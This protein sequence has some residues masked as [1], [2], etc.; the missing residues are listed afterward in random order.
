M[1]TVP[2][3]DPGS[4]SRRDRHGGRGGGGK[5]GGGFAPR[6]R[7]NTSV[8]TPA[9]YI[10]LKMSTPSPQEAQYGGQDENLDLNQPKPPYSS[11]LSRS[12]SFPTFP[13][14]YISLAAAYVFRKLNICSSQHIYIAIPPPPFVHY[15]LPWFYRFGWWLRGG[16]YWAIMS[17]ITTGRSAVQNYHF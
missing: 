2:V 9:S 10:L 12:L 14:S 13:A 16:I 3:P 6:H 11:F 7:I 8:S 1:K 15:W 5:G 4:S 17:R